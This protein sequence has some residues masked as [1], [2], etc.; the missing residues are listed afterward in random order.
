MLCPGTTRG[1]VSPSKPLISFNRTVELLV[2]ILSSL[3]ILVRT[4][5]LCHHS[6]DR[7][8]HCFHSQKLGAIQLCIKLSVSYFLCT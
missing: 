2:D 6:F 5:V 1:P 3:W 8:V 4:Y 7:G